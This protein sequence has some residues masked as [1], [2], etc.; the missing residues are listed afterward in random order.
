MVLQV[1]T[2]TIAIRHHWNDVVSKNE[3][4]LLVNLEIS[5][6]PVWGRKADLQLQETEWRI[7]LKQVGDSRSPN[8]HKIA[9]AMV[10]DRETEPF[11][12][13]GKPEPN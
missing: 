6:G 1:T 12:T 13:P 3:C 7:E 10:V 8:D 2:A 9:A 4:L 11:S 5:E